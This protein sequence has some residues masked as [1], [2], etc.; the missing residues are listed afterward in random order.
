MSD[1][2]LSWRRVIESQVRERKLALA[3]VRQAVARAEQMESL[4]RD[5]RDRRD[6]AER[7]RRARGE[8]PTFAQERMNALL[9]RAIERAGEKVS[10]ARAAESAAVDSL[11]EA[12]Q[13]ATAVDRLVARRDARAEIETRRIEQKELDE[14]ASH[15]RRFDPTLAGS[16]ELR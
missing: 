5:E 8:L 15:G 14:I 2:L 7:E 11:R 16:E 6:V 13:S 3:R 9:E 1:G 12:W 10:A 4:L